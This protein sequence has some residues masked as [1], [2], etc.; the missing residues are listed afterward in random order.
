MWT[1]AQFDSI[2]VP[3]VN[4][5]V[6][7]CGEENHSDTAKAQRTRRAGDGAGGSM[8]YSAAMRIQP[9]AL[10]PGASARRPSAAGSSM[11]IALG[12]ALTGSA[13]K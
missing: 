4:P 5:P 8:F 7:R 9:D 3:A 13:Q 11:F 10:S 1:A 12:T 2:A 6:A